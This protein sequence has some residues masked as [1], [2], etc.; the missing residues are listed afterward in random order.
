MVAPKKKILPQANR[1]LPGSKSQ[2]RAEGDPQKESKIGR[3]KHTPPC[4]SAELFCA[5]NGGHR[6]KISVVD[7]VCLVFKGFL[8]PPPTWKV[9]L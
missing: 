1:G 7:R 2:K 4:S 9:F 6:G 5:K 3:K 8:Y